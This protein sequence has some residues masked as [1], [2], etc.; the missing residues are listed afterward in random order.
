MTCLRE[1]PKL[2]AYVLG[3][4][5]LAAWSIPAR[6]D[7][8]QI[9]N[10]RVSE[11][12][13]D[14][15]VVIAAS[16]RPTFTT[17]K[18]EQPA[19]VVVELSG[20]RLGNVDVPLDAGTYAV[21]LVS[22]SVTE[23]ESAGPRTRIVLTLRQ[24]SDYRV[25]AKGSDI[26][27]RVIPRVRPP[28]A[29][30]KTDGI[31]EARVRAEAKAEAEAQTKAE[32]R[33]K[34]EAL[35]KAESEAKA[36]LAAL[37]QVKAEAQAKLEA[38][39]QAE[40]ESKAK[41]EAQAQAKA[42]SKAKTEAQAQAKAESK[43]KAE[44]QAQAKTEAEARAHAQADAETQT[45]LASQAKAQAEERAQA[46]AKA[47]ARLRTEEKQRQAAQEM[48]EEKSRAEAAARGE[49][50][51][52]RKELATA[53]RETEMARAEAH[54][55]TAESQ[56]QSAAL[57]RAEAMIKQ[58]QADADRARKQ[59]AVAES[60][61]NRAR[62]RESDRDKAV[63]VAVL[64]VEGRQKALDRMAQSQEEQRSKLAAAEQLVAKR[65]DSLR[66]SQAE[67]LAREEESRQARVRR[68]NLARD[69][70]RQSKVEAAAAL[71]EAERQR[72]E[73]A[74]IAIQSRQELAQAIAARKQEEAR[75]ENQA[76][77]R[78]TEEAKLA[79]AVGLRKSEEARLDAA[80]EQRSRIEMERA[81]LE[82]DQAELEASRDALSA[83][84]E[85][86]KRVALAAGQATP[87]ARKSGEA[88]AG[89]AQPPARAAVA[90][91]PPAPATVATLTPAS[92]PSSIPMAKS[93]ADPGA[94]K[95][96][97]AG[98]RPRSITLR[99][100]SQ[101]R[102]IDFVDEP[103]RASVIIDVDESTSFTVERLA[104]RRMSLRL[105]HSDL[106]DNLARHLDTTEFLGPVKIISSYRD[107]AARTTVR[108]DVDLAE[109]VPNRVRLDGNRIFWDFQKGQGKS[110]SL[111][112]VVVPPPT[113]L[114][115]PARKVAGFFATPADAIWQAQVTPPPYLVPPGSTPASSAAGA[116]AAARPGAP[117][118][119]SPAGSQN[120]PG[121][122]GRYATLGKKR[123]TGRRIDLDFKGADIHNILRLLADVGQV[124][125]VVADDVR[126]DVTI[127][128][129]DVP[130]DQA[131]DV[132]LRSKG[133]G[134]VR[135]GNL[136]RVAPLALLEK[137][138]EAEIARQK[139]IAEVVP[140][141][142]RLIGISY[143]E[144]G[145]M[146]EKARDLLSPRGKI[147]QDHR[148]NTLIVSDVAKNLQLIEDLVRNLDTQTSQVTIEARIVE[149]NSNF[150]RQLGVQWGGTAFADSTHGNPTGLVFPYNVG[151]GGG[152]DDGS[153]PLGGLVPGPRTGNGATGSPNFLVNMPAPA[154]LGTGSAIGL[155]LGSVAGAFNLN[156]RLSAMETTGQV[157]I[158]SSPRIT[159]MDNVEAN[160]SQGVSIPVSVVSAMGAQTQFVDARLTLAVKP[161]VTNEGTIALNINVSR[162]EPDFVNTGA[163][164]DPSIQRKEAKT[165][166][167]VRDGD[168]AVIGGIYTRNT[169]LSNARVP[170]FSD[171]PV[172]GWF[173]RNKKENDN[174]SEFLVFITPRI[175]NRARALGQ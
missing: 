124:N 66:T 52:L 23:D 107:P 111:P 24:T 35:A 141:E 138:L 1:R 45:R 115:V 165:S 53:R 162:N 174:R 119:T 83:E 156:L 149:A 157:R 89:P 96:A 73:A 77:A 90:P 154:G 109:E 62:Q 98:S 147:S 21:G 171:I 91:P 14:T 16:A 43:A 134:S 99:A 42:E 70:S 170:F 29:A 59:A 49:A 122:G 80:R 47:E 104:G 129:R 142:T 169:G 82:H 72:K 144:S 118:A 54:A 113:V 69:A 67:L 114:F 103:G 78:K 56:R 79:Q 106:P 51:Q 153:S 143:A 11:A 145:E 12:S 110:P 28:V 61:A 30:A 127:K 10:I 6:A 64:E 46:Q 126:G 84:V 86:L 85:R 87:A 38:Q 37:A 175:A 131:L 112:A 116:P 15:S 19:R 65:E 33:A 133:L 22:A 76:Q 71:S 151:I 139:Q 130:W 168:T 161:H 9:R 158:L 102:G 58:A 26:T 167:L 94:T 95:P 173:F 25:E 75:K 2:L 155:T 121:G 166:M 146:M 40:A 105:D 3:A 164:G 55:A 36:K 68:D 152:A 27:L 74:R 13:G 31:A 63:K 93:A 120:A 50:E 32:A 128:M 117:A 57:A 41:T 132:V 92:S 7:T 81:R 39:A 160:I 60:D 137:E 17:W 123:Y 44:A 48:A 88:P 18:L 136:L 97:P 159:T 20:A 108:I 150:A 4:A 34:T 172:L 5:G 140:V 100:L 148:T 163:R 135:E 101:V 125:V 8:V